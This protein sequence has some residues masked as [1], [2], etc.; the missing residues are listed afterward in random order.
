MYPTVFLTDVPL[1]LLCLTA[2]V[3]YTC[4]SVDV[5]PLHSPV[6]IALSEAS[7][8]TPSST[9][10]RAKY[11]GKYLQTR[12]ICVVT[13]VGKV[14]VE[15]AAT[16]FCSWSTNSDRYGHINFQGVRGKISLCAKPYDSVAAAKADTA[17][18]ASNG[19]SDL[20]GNGA[21]CRRCRS[22]EKRKEKDM[23]VQQSQSSE[24]ERGV[25]ST[26]ETRET[27]KEGDRA[28]DRPT[29][30]SPRRGLERQKRATWAE[31]VSAGGVN[32]YSDST[33]AK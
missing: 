10:H 30:G 27:V 26:E 14:V 19:F 28:S 29:R 6:L 24:G 1:Y 22:I 2:A 3:Q 9:V 16:S 18:F 5:Q 15:V 13:F 33:L 25:N 17:S 7:A 20:I 23:V 21:L 8:V 11:V 4:V 12:A 32:I 31:V